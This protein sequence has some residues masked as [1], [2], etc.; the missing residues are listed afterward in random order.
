MTY[1]LTSYFLLLGATSE[2]F[3]TRLFGLDSFNSEDFV[4]IVEY[5]LDGRW[6]VLCAPTTRA[7]STPQVI[8]GELGYP[9]DRTSY[10]TSVSVVQ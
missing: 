7:S 1:I 4:G 10:V 5:F 3:A 8:C 2:D 6:G 9:R